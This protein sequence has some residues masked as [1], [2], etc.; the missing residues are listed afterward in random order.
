MQSLYTFSE[1]KEKKIN[2]APIMDEEKTV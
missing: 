2:I 1:K